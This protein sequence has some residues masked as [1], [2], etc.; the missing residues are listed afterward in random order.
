MWQREEQDGW[1]YLTTHPGLPRLERVL[2][3]GQVRELV[4][5]ARASQRSV[6]GDP[7]GFD[8]CWL[9]EAR[10]PPV[11]AVLV[12]LPDLV[13]V[14]VLVVQLDVVLVPA[15]AVHGGCEIRVRR[16]AELTV[17]LSPPRYQPRLDSQHCYRGC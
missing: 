17:E 2:H 8:P 12:D 1:K 15:E 4:P 16:C 10:S 9:S 7:G 11:V 13:R 3:E 5:Y 6:C 14:G